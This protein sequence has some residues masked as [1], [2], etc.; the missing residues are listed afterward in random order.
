MLTDPSTILPP[1]EDGQRLFVCV[2]APWQEALNE[3]RTS[4]EDSTF[5]WNI[6][7]HYKKGDWVLTYLATRPRVFLCWEQATED[8]TPRGKLRVDYSTSVFF[9]NLVVVDEIEAATGYSISPR[10]TFECYEAQK[11][12]HELIQ[13]LFYPRSWHGLNGSVRVAG[14]EF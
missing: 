14:A 7:D 4:R 8:A 1:I 9:D 3:I 11:I 6:A 10:S 5:G 13:Q 12:R 2:G